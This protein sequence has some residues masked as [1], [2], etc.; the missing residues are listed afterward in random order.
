MADG[1]EKKFGMSAEEIERLVP[2]TGGCLATDRIVV[3]GAPIAYIYR[4]APE[5]SVHSGWVFTAGDEDEEY[6]DTPENWGIY[7]VN[8]VCNYDPAIIPYLDA[9][10]G[11]V[12][13]R[14]EDSDEFEEERVPFPDF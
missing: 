13:V 5:G 12:L 6:I 1:R 2:D 10:I 8:T 11:T 9:P 4:E 14:V 7:E 3:D